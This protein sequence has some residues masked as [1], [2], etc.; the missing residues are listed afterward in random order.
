MS[1][2]KVL[3]TIARRL[4]ETVLAHPVRVAIDGID[5]AGKTTFA[6]HL[7]DELRLLSRPIIRASADHFQNP[8]SIRY[9]RG[10]KSPAAYF[11]D[12]FNIESMISSLLKP[13]GAGGNYCYKTAVFDYRTN[14][15]IDRPFKVADPNAIL[16]M[17]GVF[18]MRPEL[19]IYW[20]IGIWLDVSFENALQ[21]ALKRDLDQLGDEDTIRRR[22]EHKYFPAQ[23]HYIERCNPK[24]MADFIIDNN[25]V[26]MP[27]LVET[28]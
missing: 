2:L 3:R 28:R 17:D 22:Y 5:V 23:K 9:Q 15:P 6:D 11:E 4:T 21:R 27:I 26:E 18:L 8:R 7:A 1:R 24:R 19:A 12:S 25:D 10:E 20:D 14:L 13:L 16:L